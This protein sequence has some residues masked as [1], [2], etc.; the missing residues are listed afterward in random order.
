MKRPI[1]DDEGSVAIFVAAVTP[2]LVLAFGLVADLG[3]HLRAARNATDV[4]QE[5]ARA[6]A[7][8]VDASLYSG[9]GPLAISPTRAVKVAETYLHSAGY[10]GT[11]TVTGPTTISVS[12]TITQPSPVL[13]RIGVGPF[14]VTETASA[15]L[16]RGL[17]KEG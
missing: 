9:S 11:A 17:D 13:S 7:S 10:T 3:A 14:Q 12:V 5:A 1:G 4:A 15:S 8:S 2:G 6:G 16:L